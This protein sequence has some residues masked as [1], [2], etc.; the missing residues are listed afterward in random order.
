MR[1]VPNHFEAQCYKIT[2]MHFMVRLMMYAKRESFIIYIVLR[3]ISRKFL[4]DKKYLRFVS[5]YNVD[6][7]VFLLFLPNAIKFL[8]F[9]RLGNVHHY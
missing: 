4:S 3:K 7:K 6:Y 8:T 9:L 5:N 1:S 2:E